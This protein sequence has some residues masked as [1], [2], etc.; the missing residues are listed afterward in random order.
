MARD[1]HGIGWGG[2]WVARGQGPTS[3]VTP[4]VKGRRRSPMT[5]AAKRVEEALAPKR[6]I[7][8]PAGEGSPWTRTTTNSISAWTPARVRQPRSSTSSPPHSGAS[9]FASMSTAVDRPS[10]GPAPADA[11]GVDLAIVGQLIVEFGK[12]GPVLGQVIEVVQAWAAR[13]PQRTAKLTIGD[14][15]LELTGMSEPTSTRSSARGWPVTRSP[16][17]ESPMRWGPVAAR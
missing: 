3:H 14:D 17:P 10:A 15:T 4:R 1:L 9:S 11:R 8:T 2:C 16:R 13:S 5:G 7:V 12:A 6:T